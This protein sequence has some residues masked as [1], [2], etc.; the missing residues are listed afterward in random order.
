MMDVC[1]GGVVNIKA[2]VDTGC[3]KTVIRSE[4][5]ELLLNQ[6]NS[7]IQPGV[8]HWRTA[9]GSVGSSKYKMVTSMRWGYCDSKCTV[10]FRFTPAIS[11]WVTSPLSFSMII[12][13]DL[14]SYFGA[15]ICMGTG[16]L[17][18]PSQV[19]SV[20]SLTNVGKT[21]CYNKGVKCKTNR[22][23]NCVQKHKTYFS[24][25]QGG[26]QQQDGATT[27]LCSPEVTNNKISIGRM[28]CKPPKNPPKTYYTLS[29]KIYN[30]ICTYFGILPELDCFAS[31]HN[32]KCSQYISL[33]E[34]EKAVGMDFW[35]KKHFKLLEKKVLW[36]NPQW[37]TLPQLYVHLSS[38]D[39]VNALV[40]APLW[41]QTIYYRMFDMVSVRSY[42]VRRSGHLFTSSEGAHMPAT[43]YDF[44]VWNFRHGAPHHCHCCD[45]SE[46]NKAEGASNQLVHDM[47]AEVLTDSIPRSVQTL[48]DV[49]TDKN[50]VALPID[51]AGDGHCA[52]LQSDETCKDMDIPD[53][54]DGDWVTMT[55][56][57]LQGCCS[58]MGTEA[59]PN[60]TCTV[61]WGSDGSAAWTF[62][63][64]LNAGSMA[65]IIGSPSHEEPGVE[66]L[67]LKYD[68][69]YG[70]NTYD[71]KVCKLHGAQY[72]IEL[73]PQ[74]SPF[75][76][77][78]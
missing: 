4:V 59:N 38:L 65:G 48:L 1:L 32:S 6:K 5:A 50:L 11:M 77:S 14:L 2:L 57:E 73:L 68:H 35:N 10:K 56:E 30:D 75:R 60:I 39:T 55:K 13:C 52:C 12:G 45:R 17:P 62:K 37:E 40:F 15:T 72:L 25:V 7:H 16:K 49:Q 76:S 69:L 26:V 9:D 71:P 74:V 21:I 63:E 22:N 31:E 19:P 43:N 44:I 64:D 3:D 28:V 27:H 67:L 41:C 34:E 70:D 20:S 51:T 33:N 47:Q 78:P 66:K 46:L 29:T 23:C 24:C 54:D 36:C 58:V 42:V 53:R 8:H 18:M 61:G